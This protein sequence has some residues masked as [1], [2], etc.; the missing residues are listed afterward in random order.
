MSSAEDMTIARDAMTPPDLTKAPDLGA[1]A[2]LAATPD[3]ATPPDLALPHPTAERLAVTIQPHDVRAGEMIAFSVEARDHMDVIVSDFT[4]TATV[5]VSGGSAADPLSGA[6]S[7][8]FVS[9]VAT[10]P[11]LHIDHVG[12]AYVL[13]ASTSGLGGVDSSSFDVGGS[14]LAFR[15]GPPWCDRT[16]HC[17]GLGQVS[18]ARLRLR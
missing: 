17:Q 18:V 3:L 14:R 10:F 4:S 16:G 1:P 2:D 6:L 12:Q 15:S 13:H 11:D 5:T 7:V 8:D 9:G